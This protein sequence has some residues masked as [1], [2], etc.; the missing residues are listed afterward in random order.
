[1]WCHGR[2]LQ[3]DSNTEIKI[4]AVCVSEVPVGAGISQETELRRSSSPSPKVCLFSCSRLSVKTWACCQVLSPPP[5]SSPFWQEKSRSGLRSVFA[6]SLI[7]SALC[8][9][10]W[11]SWETWT[12]QNHFFPVNELSCS[13]F[14]ARKGQQRNSSHCLSQHSLSR[15]L[16]DLT[17]KKWFRNSN[18]CYMFY[19]RVLQRSD[20]SSLQTGPNRQI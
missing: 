19:E 17:M 6:S 8:W 13:L 10:L 4:E 20:L 7:F 5:G 12:E 2:W 9:T 18:S 15:H 3:E 1:M 11:K 14:T 16:A